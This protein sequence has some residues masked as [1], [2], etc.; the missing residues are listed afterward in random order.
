M[1][2]ESDR[3]ILCQGCKKELAEN[4]KPCSVCGSTG[5]DYSMKLET[6]TFKVTVGALKWKQNRPGFKK[7]IMEGINRTKVS[8]DPKL[9]QQEVHE[10]YVIDRIKKWWKQIVRSV[11]TGEIIHEE[12]KSF[13][14]KNN[15][16]EK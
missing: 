6:E 11:E 10:I 16:L 7:P 8:R 15:N 1:I 2:S 9:N 4:E 12:D 3:L 5:R 13:D 14:E